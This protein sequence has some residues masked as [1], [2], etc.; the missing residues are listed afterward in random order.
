MVRGSVSSDARSLGRKQPFQRQKDGP[1]ATQSPPFIGREPELRQL[2]SVF[3]A[4]GRGVG[5][6]VLLA[7]EPG[8]GKSALCEQMARI[9]NSGDGQSLIGHCYEEGASGLPYQ[10]FVEA[11]VSY[12]SRREPDALRCELGT[13]AGDLARMVPMIRELLQIPV[14]ASS[15][16][17]DDR[18]RLLSA[19]LAF[20]RSIGAVHPLLLVLEDLHDADRGTLDLLLHLAR[21]LARTPVLILGTY[22]DVQVDRAHPLATALTELRRVGDCARIDLSGLSVDEVQRVLASTSQRPVPRSLAELIHHRTEGNPLFTH[23]MLRFFIAEGLVERPDGGPGEAWRVQDTLAARVPEGLRDVVGKRLTKLSATANEVLHVASVIGREFRLDILRRVHPMSDEELEYALEESAAAA[24]VEERSVVG[25]VVTYRFSHAFFRQTLYEEM[26]APRRIRLHQTIAQVLED[27][28]AGRLNEHASELADH[29]AFS[30]DAANLLEAVQYGRLAALRARD[31]FAYGEAARQLERAVSIQ[32]LQPVADHGL[33]CDLLLELGEALSIT[34]DSERAIAHAAPEALKLAESMGDRGRAFRACRVALE[35]LEYWG[36]SLSASTLTFQQWAERADRYAESDSIQRAQ[37]NLWLGLASVTRGQLKEARA[38]RAEALEIARRKSDRETMFL[39][40]SYLIASLGCMSPRYW[41][42]RVRLARE[43]AEWSRDGVSGRALG[44]L[45]SFAGRI[46]LAEGD[47]ARAVD[48]WSQ[49]ED[50]AERTHVVA[51]TLFVLERDVTLAIIDG[52]LEEGWTLMHH[53]L[54]RADDLGATLRAR[55]YSVDMRLTLATLLGRGDDMLGSLR[56]DHAARA[57]ASMQNHP[58]HD[59]RIAYIAECLAHLGRMDE[60]RSLARALL[61]GEGRQTEENDRDTTVLLAILRCAIALEHRESAR[62]VSARLGQVAHL[63]F[64]DLL[65]TSV[66]RQ[67]GAAAALCG[68][69]LAARGYY[70]Q[71]LETAARIGFRPDM[72]LTHLQFGELL[73]DEGEKAAALE[74]L[75]IA[76]S[77]LR[78]MQMHPALARA[79]RVEDSARRPELPWQYVANSDRLTSREREVANLVAQGRSNRAIADELVISEGTVE[80]HI[81]HIL[82]KLGFRS[83]SQIATWVIDRQRR[84]AA[85]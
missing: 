36:A 10:A 49:M 51:V 81:K 65:M 50:L 76:V 54:D 23:E 15:D 82:S 32:E 80:V 53:F 71:A 61:D 13:N 47:R 77:E 3:E 8:I 83:R 59:A 70:E 68:D 79:L 44:R 42:E 22:R 45:L 63:S 4:A 74:H 66:A 18:W 20:I 38:L 34:G 11:F 25:A 69:R 46:A 30:S 41:G 26:L 31:V 17:Q 16:P 72:A 35:S 24:I 33:H 57:T 39:A 60:A 37:A 62:A 9:A 64:G 1:W 7:G 19:V 43:A 52:R 28:Y 58:A 40:A 6:L 21:N 84:N 14:S 56:D 73:L 75:D 5:R 78:E 12:A 48:L 27:V 85:G 67:L 2:R 29:Y 55:E